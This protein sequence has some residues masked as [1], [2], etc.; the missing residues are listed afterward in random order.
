MQIHRNARSLVPRASY[1]ERSRRRN[2]SDNSRQYRAP[3]LCNLTLIFGIA[4]DHCSMSDRDLANRMIA[5]RHASSPWLRFQV[6]RMSFRISKLL[7]HNDTRVTLL[8][9]CW[10]HRRATSTFRLNEDFDAELCIVRRKQCICIALYVSRIISNIAS[11]KSTFIIAPCTFTP[12]GAASEARAF[13][14]LSSA[15]FSSTREKVSREN[16][17]SRNL[18]SEFF[19][20]ALAGECERAL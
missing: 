7:Y 11:W 15:N 8:A 17:F 5:A 18:L 16:L 4:L 9:W 2:E 13:E 20:L 3:V 19:V 12:A 1:R 14:M 10:L 6:S